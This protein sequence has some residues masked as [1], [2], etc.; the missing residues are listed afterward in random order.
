MRKPQANR[1]GRLPPRPVRPP[2]RLVSLPARRCRI[3]GQEVEPMSSSASASPAVAGPYREATRVHTSLLAAVEKHALVWM[4]RRLPRWVNSDHLTLL[5]LGAMVLAG[6]S[7]WLGQF[8]PAGF[9]FV[10]VLLAVNWFG[11]SLDGTLARVRDQQRPRYGYYVDH[12]IDAVG[13]TVLLGGIALSGSMTPLVAAALLVAYLLVCVE[14]YLA[15]HS[16]GT[17]TLSFFKVGPT[18]LRI[19]LALGALKLAVE[20]TVTVF[21]RT[22]LLFD[23]GGVIA[24][25]GLLLTLATSTARNTRALY[26]AEPVPAGREE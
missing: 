20:P 15:T 16:L 6:V 23:I 3:H 12:V 25:A 24:I 11:D 7:F 18:E 26:R 19:I 14:V 13:I 21:G 9:V 1:L 5:A 17:F 4:A 8:H 2:A 10:I 22:W